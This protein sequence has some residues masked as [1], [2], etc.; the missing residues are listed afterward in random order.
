MT[1]K[2]AKPV[3]ITAK[4]MKSSLKREQRGIWY[5]KRVQGKGGQKSLTR[6]VATT[7]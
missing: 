4:S 1:D 6:C 2:T 3:G 5:S 7:Y